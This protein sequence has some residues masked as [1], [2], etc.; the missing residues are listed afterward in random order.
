MY[1]GVTMHHLSDL[2]AAEELRVFAEMGW[3]GVEMS[4]GRI[5]EIVKA[6]NPEKAADDFRA[7]AADVGLQ[8]PQVHLLM[9]AN[10]ATADDARREADLATAMREAE[11]AA[12]AGVEIGVIHPAGDR[13]DTL[14]ELDAEEARRIQTFARL[15]AH[16]AQFGMSIAVE[17]TYDGKLEGTAAHGERRFGSII[18]EL[19][20]LIDA[21]DHPSFGI[22]LDTGHSHLMGISMAE[23]VRQC[24]DRLIATHL[25]DNNRTADQHVCPFY[26]GVD[27]VEGTAAL[28]EIGYEG[29]FN[30]EI[31][32][33]GP[34][35]PDEI[36]LPRLRYALKIANWL[37]SE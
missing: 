12:R 13:P 36:R 24:G 33:G 16:T 11:L 29:I 20:G 32:G 6:E 34:D 28:R 30:F 37:L 18:P 27:W 15:V 21:V 25:D 9:G 22:C 4:C 7:A 31:G 23:S 3:Q 35:T 2:P 26:G 8:T 10:L 17:N 19:H 1:P 14:A 5:A